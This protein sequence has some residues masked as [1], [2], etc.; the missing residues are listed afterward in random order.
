MN[1][2]QQLAAHTGKRVPAMLAILET[3]VNGDRQWIAEDVFS[4]GEIQP[5]L[6]DIG[7]LLGRVQVNTH[8]FP[9]A[10]LKSFHSRI[11]I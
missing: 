5:L 10:R 3:F 4:K 1:D 7:A 2:Q 6:P 11:L 9:P 8:A